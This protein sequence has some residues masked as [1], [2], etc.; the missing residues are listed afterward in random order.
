M[1]FY[2]VELLDKTDKKV[3]VLQQDIF[4][5]NW[6]YDTLGGCGQCQ[7]GL[8][9]EF[10]DYGTVNLDYGVKIWRIPNPYVVMQK[11]F[12]SVMVIDWFDHADENPASGY[13]VF[14][15]A[16]SGNLKVL[17]KH[18]AAASAYP[19]S[20][21]GTKDSASFGD[22]QEA[23]FTIGAIHQTSQHSVGVVL[24]SPDTSNGYIVRIYYNGPNWIVTANA[25]NSD[26]VSSDLF[27]VEVASLSVGDRFG[28]RITGQ[29]L[30]VFLNGEKIATHD[31]DESYHIS[32][33]AKVGLFILG[34]NWMIREFGGGTYSPWAGDEATEQLRW[35]GFV[36]QIAP[37]FDQKESVRLN[38]VG[39]ARQL[40]Y[41]QVPNVTYANVD[42]TSIALGIVNSYA[43]TGTRVLNT[44]SESLTALTGVTVSTSGLSFDSSVYDAIRTLAE[45]GGNAEW[46]VDANREFYFLPRTTAVKQTIP[47]NAAVKTYEPLPMGSTDEMVHKVY[48]RG[49]AGSTFTLVGT[50]AQVG[51]QKE[52]IEQVSAIK[53]AGDATLWGTAYFAKHGTV[54]PR[55]HMTL[56]TPDMWVEGVRHPLGAFRVIGSPTFIQAGLTLPFPLP[57]TFGSRLIGSVTDTSYRVEGVSYT[58]V[59]QGL[60]ISIDLG[61]KKS[62]LADLF[63]GIEH[64]I[65]EL[66][67][68]LLF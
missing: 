22:N 10:D 66:R 11:L 26:V 5:L 48:L 8:R 55:A 49:A 60:S 65:T 23:Y 25:V 63:I 45:I 13:S 31:I 59:E 40:Q 20:C 29:T 35:S 51:Y 68:G 28:A 53:T 21:Y 54:K 67:Q 7:I 14:S 2:Q 12:P 50:T 61:E 64:K 39:Y 46:G 43:L 52:R 38:C 36:Q 32:T 62:S 16:G 42:V 27:T 3:E 30:H 24:R 1:F 9:R 33:G 44:A 58:P 34:A 37:V 15:G 41:V 47:L 56:V 57:G 17:S 18:M 19:T 4:S 6:T